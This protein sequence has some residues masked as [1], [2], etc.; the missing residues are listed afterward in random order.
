MTDFTKLLAQN[1]DQVEKPK[2]TPVGTYT[3]LITGYETGES[4]QKKTPFVRI[5]YKFVS[6]QADVDIEALAEA[7]GMEKISARMP[8]DDFYLTPD[9]MHR[10]KTFIETVGV[11]STG[12]TFSECLPEL[13]NQTVNAHFKHTMST[14]NPGEVFAEID[15][16]SAA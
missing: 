3:M 5:N 14:K 1:L 8:K 11:N 2:P 9:A 13:V 6:P 15:G 10:L 16:Y 12:R 4:A 7:G